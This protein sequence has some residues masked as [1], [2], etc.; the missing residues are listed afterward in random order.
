MLTI[1]LVAEINIFPGNVGTCLR[2]GGITLLQFYC[3][4]WRDGSS[5]T[6]A[7]IGWSYH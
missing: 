6:P 2:C 4:M 1:Q 7:T 5:K 3:W